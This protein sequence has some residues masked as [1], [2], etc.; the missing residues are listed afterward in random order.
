[1]ACRHLTTLWAS[2]ACYRDNFTFTY[3]DFK[4]SHVIWSCLQK[5]E[6]QFIE[7]FRK[8]IHRLFEIGVLLPSGIFKRTIRW[9][10]RKMGGG[11]IF[12]LT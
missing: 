6:L 8:K 12:C 4:K 9:M 10:Y 5:M 11:F 2:T 3:E 1:M 7:I